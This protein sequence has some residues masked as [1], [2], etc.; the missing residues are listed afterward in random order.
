[1]M[2][3]AILRNVVRPLA[4]RLSTNSLSAVIG[5][6]P[7]LA[8]SKKWF[9]KR[10]VVWVPN[11]NDLPRE[12]YDLVV[13]PLTLECEEQPVR[14]LTRIRSFLT[15]SGSVCIAVFDSKPWRRIILG[16]KWTGF[17]MPNQRTTFDLKCLDRMLRM[18][19]LRAI[20]DSGLPSLTGVEPDT[21]LPERATT[22]QARRV[23][24]AEW[25]FSP[26]FA[27]QRLSRSIA[28]VHARPV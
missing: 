22:L 23:S 26:W 18:A 17:S 16:H 9:S 24:T 15:P 4:A 2:Q 28:L 13:L 11:S 7:D 3:K 25:V 27:W 10:N 8:L 12:Q 20:P 6:E 19:D 5:A 14:A 1:M 21:E